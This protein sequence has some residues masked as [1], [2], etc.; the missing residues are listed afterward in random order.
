MSLRTAL[1]PAL[2]CILAFGAA[3][4]AHA[5]HV[6]CGETI[7][8]DTKLD[9]D[10]VDCPS[11]GIVIGAD[12]ITLNLNGHRIDGDGAEFAACPEDE[13]CDAGILVDRHTGVK[14]KGGTIR[15]FA[16]GAFILRARDSRLV[17]ISSSRND[18]FGA[19]IVV[20]KESVLRDGSFGDNIPPEGDGIGVFDSRGSR[21]VGN[22]V[23]RNPGPGIH[24]EGST[25]TLIKGNRMASNGPSIL[26]EADRNDVRG[27]RISGGDGILVAQG[28]R[29]AVR[30]NRVSGAGEGLA[31]EDGSDNVFARNVVVGAENHG[32]RLGIGNPALGGDHNILRRNLVRDSGKN[33]FYVYAKDDHSLLRRN[34]AIG[35][36]QDGFRV[37]GRATTLRGNRADRNAELGIHAVQGTVDGGANV[38]SH[39]GDPRQC[40]NVVCR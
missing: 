33:G 13:N 20:S 11:N 30:G 14:V 34:V 5:D 28:D 31:V 24:V 29:N 8:A 17:E 38:A 10:L 25:G 19:L 6:A 36:G 16:F 12:E 39:N 9:S 7:T 2:A 23:E 37:D 32:I 15:G 21:I 26:I 35:S 22:A 27:N 18:F 4:S 3:D 40:T 1:I